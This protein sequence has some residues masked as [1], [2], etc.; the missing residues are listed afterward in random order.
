MAGWVSVEGADADGPVMMDA[1]GEG[2]YL[3]HNYRGE[4]DR[5]G[6]FFVDALTQTEPLGPYAVIY[7]HKM[8]TGEIFGNLERYKDPAVAEAHPTFRFDT[9]YESYECDIVA[10]VLTH[11][12]RENEEGFRY[13]RMKNYGS[14]KK[15]RALREFIAENELYHTGIKLKYG[16]PVVILSTCDYAVEEGRLLLVG[17]RRT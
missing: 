5:A 3:S 10:A 8:H 16:D 9:L 14:R 7:G 11:V 17:R 6:S 15:F 2:Y 12:M 13:Y 4:E 1:E